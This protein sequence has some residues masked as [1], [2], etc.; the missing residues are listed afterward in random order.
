MTAYALTHST[1][2]KLGIAGAPVTDWSLYD[3]IYTERYMDLPQRNPEGY[4]KS[5]VLAAAGNLSGKLLLIHGVIDENVH[6]QNSMK[7][8][9]ALQLAGKQVQFMAYPRN[10]HGVVNPRQAR[11]LQ[12]MMTDF[13]RTNL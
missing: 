10:R 13:V 12:Q 1:R 8:L 11:H 7:F 9:D 5:S 4:R 2:F 6:L 3:S